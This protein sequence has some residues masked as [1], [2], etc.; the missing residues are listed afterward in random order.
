MVGQAELVVTG[1]HDRHQLA[2]EMQRVAG[3]LVDVGTVD[4]R[5]GRGEELAASVFG[6]SVSPAPMMVL[7]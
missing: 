3:S 4:E 7:G 2:A 1:L 6:L 5:R